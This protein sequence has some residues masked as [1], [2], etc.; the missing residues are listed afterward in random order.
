MK[1]RGGEYLKIK[2][3]SKKIKVRIFSST[4]CLVPFVF[5]PIINGF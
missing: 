5:Y 3:K 2:D 4:F 1:G